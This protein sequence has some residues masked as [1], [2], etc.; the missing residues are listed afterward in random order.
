MSIVRKYNFETSQISALAHNSVG[1]QFLWVGFLPIDSG[2]C[3]L[4]KVS[5]FDPLQTYFDLE[6]TANKIVQLH[7]SALSFVYMAVDHET[8]CGY[9]YSV[10]T[11]NTGIVT[12]TKPVEITEN[13]IGFTLD[14][15]YVY[16]LLPGKESGTEAKILKYSLTGTYLH[17][18]ELTGVTD[19]I[20]ITLDSDLWVI[21]DENPSRLV[22]VYGS[23]TSYNTQ[24][25]TLG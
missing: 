21:T 20:G 16:F 8:V 18:I 23:G 6:I 17:T 1:G 3:N 15:S 25:T 9:R 13:P 4:K 2:V 5:A 11:P 14:T 10:L 7:S 22:R 24:I 12:Y 19:A